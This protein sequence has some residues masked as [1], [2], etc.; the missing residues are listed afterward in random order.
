M[1]EQ[2]NDFFI[3]TNKALC[4]IDLP[5]NKKNDKMQINF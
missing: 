4:L 5:K 2:R 1:L 3:K